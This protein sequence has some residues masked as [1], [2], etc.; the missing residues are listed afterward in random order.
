MFI[1]SSYWVRNNTN[2]TMKWIWNILSSE[3]KILITTCG[4]L[5]DFSAEDSKR[6]SLNSLNSARMIS[7]EIS[8]LLADNTVLHHWLI[9]LQLLTVTMKHVIAEQMRVTRGSRLLY[10]LPCLSV[11]LSHG[12]A[13]WAASKKAAMKRNEL[14]ILS[15]ADCTADPRLRKLLHGT[16][17]SVVLPFIASCH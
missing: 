13:P 6:N 15:A 5:N 14:K 12:T 17:V 11:C 7:L 16:G 1:L 10:S 4:N 3:D 8:F 9:S 2:S